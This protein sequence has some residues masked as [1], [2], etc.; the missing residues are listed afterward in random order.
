MVNRTA[1]SL[2]GEDMQ[3]SRTKLTKVLNSTFAGLAIL[4]VASTTITLS[5]R[6]AVAE[7]KPKGNVELVPPGSPGTSVDRTMRLI[8]ATWKSMGVTDFTTAVVN[9]KGGGQSIAWAYL[10]KH[11]G[12]SQYLSV[13]SPTLL[14]RGITGQT[15]VSYMRDVV[16]IALLFDDYSGIVVR[17]DSP[18][19]TA[20]GLIDR[21]KADPGSLSI[22]VSPGL[23]TPNHLAL[24]M[25]LKEAGVDITALK[26][27]I[28]SGSS[29]AVTAVI[30]GHVDLSASPT[31]TARKHLKA[32][33]VRVLAVSAPKRM[34]GEY[35]GVST[36]RE[37]GIDAVFANWRLIIAP[38]G[39]SKE[40]VAYWDKLF[41][42]T[43]K[44]DVWAAG[45][46]KN[47]WTPHYLNSTDA[48]KFL[49]SQNTQ[50]KKLLIILGLA[51]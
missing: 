7:W 3:R 29:K 51:K 37:L 11:P 32:G 22:A 16:P 47:V 1:L 13:T 45:L 30:G 35:K 42:K 15:D 44:S 10:N 31:S 34:E 6:D 12:N 27:V 23:G 38:K 41:A 9:K 18:L 24:G 5:A 28:F 33:K 46:K 20:Q 50:L 17:D 40:Q 14:I 49:D 39:T 48:V 4:A 43:V 19:K 26:T 2:E 36:W 8:D 25:A 21:L